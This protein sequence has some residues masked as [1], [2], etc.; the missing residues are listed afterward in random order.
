MTSDHTGG[1]KTFTGG[2]SVE[3]GELNSLNVNI[4]MSSTFS[5]HPKLTK[6]LLNEDFFDVQKYAMAQFKSTSITKKN[7]G[8]ELV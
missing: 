2:A 6:H 7:E 3:N 4:D 8:Y 1:F 5:D